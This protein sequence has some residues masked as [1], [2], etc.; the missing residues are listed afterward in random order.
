MKQPDPLTRWGAVAL[1][2]A[3]ALVLLVFGA[4]SINASMGLPLLLGGGCTLAAAGGAALGRWLP[5]SFAALF[6]L[7][8]TLVGVGAVGLTEG[9]WGAP[10]LTAGLLGLLLVGTAGAV[11]RFLWLTREGNTPAP[12]AV[13]AAPASASRSTNV[14]A[15]DGSALEHRLAMLTDAL[16]LSEPVRRVLYGDREREAIRG[17]FEGHLRTG[18]FDAAER[19]CAALETDLARADLASA[20]REEI[21]AIRSHAAHV[22]LREVLSQFDRHLADRNWGAA[23]AEAARIRQRFPDTE[24]IRDLEHRALAARDQHKQELRERFHQLAEADRVDEAIAVLRELDRY[25]T[26]EEGEAMA[27]AAHQVV[28][29]HRER[30]G[31]A[32]R[33][34]VQEHRWADASRVGDTIIREHPS[35]KMADEVRSMIDLI[36]TRA[37]QAA[38]AVSV[39]G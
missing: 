31:A 15:M 35:T 32:F 36:R 27:P 1:I 25:L 38:L 33:Q 24:L 39:A 12:P 37:T 6:V 18:E 3:W 5:A 4:F 34:A 11:V 14:N 30:L 16:M 28:Q 7:A 8:C 26:R 19:F 20:F 9:A 29:R 10:V 13:S 17:V 2:G 23:F 21:E 22:E